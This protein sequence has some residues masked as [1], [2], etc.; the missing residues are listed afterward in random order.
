[1]DMY[2]LICESMAMAKTNSHY[3]PSLGS[4]LRQVI[5]VQAALSILCISQQ[6]R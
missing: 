4:H 5:Y 6:M 1:M 3:D 2:V